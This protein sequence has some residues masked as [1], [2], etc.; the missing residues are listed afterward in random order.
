MAASIVQVQMYVMMQAWAKAREALKP[1]LKRNDFCN[2]ADVCYH[3]GSS[4]MWTGD[5]DIAML[6]HERGIAADPTFH[7]NFYALGF[8]MI[9]SIW[10]NEAD[11]ERKSLIMKTAEKHLWQYVK[12]G[13]P[14]DKKYCDV[15]YDLVSLAL[16]SVNFQKAHHI[17]EMAIEADIRRTQ[18]YNEPSD[19]GGKKALLFMATLIEVATCSNDPQRN[20]FLATLRT[21]LCGN[22]LLICLDIETQLKN[23]SAFLHTMRDFVSQKMTTSFWSGDK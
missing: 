2:R 12:Q 22:S 1:L 5:H 6:W 9:N 11:P 14:E 19:C 23:L 18:I 8:A 13:V 4:L 17:L 21:K 16:L 3:I 10:M 15:M 20:L 7:I